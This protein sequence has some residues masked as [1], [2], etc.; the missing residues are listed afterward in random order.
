MTTRPLL[1]RLGPVPKTFVHLDFE[2]YY[3]ADYTLR[4][5]TTE[6]YVRDERFEVIGVGV[7]VGH[8]ATVWLE[9]WDF[10]A[11]AKTVD[12]ANCAVD[13]HHAQF[14]AFILS[15]R[16]GIKPGFIFCTM[17]MG[18]VLH[19]EGALDRLAQR[20]NIGSKTDELAKMKGK[21]RS[22]LTQR[23]WEAFGRY[24][25][26]DVDLMA[27]LLKLMG[28]SFPRLELWLID[29]TVRMF[30]EP[31]FRGD[32]PLLQKTLE[33]ERAKKAAL[34]R[35]IAETEGIKVAAN[36]DALEVARSVLS[37][38][39]KFAAL[40]RAMGEVPPMKPNTKGEN[41][42]A[43]AKTDPGMAR[44]LEHENEEI[45]F[46][47]EARLAVKST[48][49]E[50][51]TER[52]IGIAQRGRVPFY[53]KFAGAHTHRW[54]GG[55]KMNPQNFNR[56]G[57]LRDAVTVDEEDEIAVCDSGQI[58][59]RV[60]PWL[61]GESSVLEVFRRN[62]EKNRKY[63]VELARLLA[64]GVPEKEAKKAAGDPGDFYSDIGSTFFMK[65]ISKAETPIERQLSK[66]MILG[67]GFG[68]GWAKF[69][70]ELL[71]GMLGAEP[72][73]FTGA[74]AAKFGV[75]V[76]AFAARS[77]GRDFGTCGQRVQEL[78]D[79]GVRLPFDAMLVHCAVADHFVRL[80][81]SKNPKVVKLWEQCETVLKVMED[82]DGK[83]D[84]AVRM[85]W[86]GLEVMRHA[87]R[88][89]NGL[90]LRYPGLRRTAH[91]YSYMGGKS[92]RERVKI[93]GGL[94][95]ENLVQSLARD[96][97]AEQA[98]EVRA[99]GHKLGTTTH[100]EIVAVVPRGAGAAALEQMVS[101][102]STPPA[103]CADLP[104]N[105]EG[106]VGRRYGDAK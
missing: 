98:L 63:L 30:T 51:R 106:G 52:L 95:T 1:E 44:L 103:W 34:L 59:A 53:L 96:I 42:Y 16:Y 61:A 23:E 82:P 79:Q 60:L 48:I 2:T 17:S 12:W 85:R 73:Q 14:D 5:L 68:M 22:D 37:S 36:D 10:R 41:I 83:P 58:E 3:D 8:A 62:D 80:Y 55:D 29:S 105:A 91:G 7:R 90:V 64:A 74:E 94:L 67:L 104:L 97:V 13:A 47:A 81:R 32:I 88:K 89:P 43:F 87:I 93:Y 65:A 69:A 50:T 84:G 33:E 92:G 46:L 77:A 49:I 20:Y 54:S 35:R 25:C 78:I 86:R 39:D 57:A 66:N 24:C 28:P 26:N 38:S 45:R 99:L 9:E 11:W 4:K 102:M 31:V 101:I 18:R 70:G 21:R 19:G 56:G 100:D 71:K 72:V 40:L 76:A 75:D 15:E 27:Q 6:A